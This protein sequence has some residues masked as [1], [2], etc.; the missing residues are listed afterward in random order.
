MQDSGWLAG[1]LAGM[2]PLQCK[3]GGLTMTC[4]TTA[5]RSLVLIVWVGGCVDVAQIWPT[6]GWGSI[7]YGTPV[8]GQ[9]IGGRWKPLHHFMAEAAYTD[10]TASCG[11]EKVTMGD[12]ECDAEGGPVLC[13]ES[14]HACLLACC[15][16]RCPS[17]QFRLV[18]GKTLRKP[19]CL[20]PAAS[21]RPRQ[22]SD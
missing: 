9:V 1:W 19:C 6:G 5:F 3:G 20:L 16:H 10:V 8:A 22:T 13:C 14:S 15:H 4:M 11:V 7:E 12:A 18:S 21:T 17:V 2:P